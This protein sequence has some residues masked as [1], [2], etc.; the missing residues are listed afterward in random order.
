MFHSLRQFSAAN[1]IDSLF[2]G[3]YS[4][5]FTSGKD[6]SSS[7]KLI[8]SSNKLLCCKALSLMDIAVV[9]AF[10]KWHWDSNIAFTTG[11]V[12][13][14]GFTPKI[15]AKAFKNNSFGILE[16]FSICWIYCLL[17]SSLSPISCNENPQKRRAWI[18][19][20]LKKLTFYLFF[21]FCYRFV[22]YLYLF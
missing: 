9:L 10:L 8:K 3:E 4:V 11:F 14:H 17:T 16:P 7:M 1:S 12:K 13:K 22:R 19:L 15:S 20:S 6:S 21:L 5:S 18:N 2:F